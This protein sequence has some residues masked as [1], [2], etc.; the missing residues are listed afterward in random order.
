MELVC[1][2]SSVND[3]QICKSGYIAD[4]IVIHIEI[5]SDL[6]K[7]AKSPVFK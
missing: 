5:L 7:P 1:S 3:V 6:F 4:G 2:A